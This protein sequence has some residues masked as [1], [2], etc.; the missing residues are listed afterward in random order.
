M[1]GDLE[2]VVVHQMEAFK[3]G[4]TGQDEKSIEESEY[5]FECI[6]LTGTEVVVCL[7]YICWLF[8][9]FAYCAVRPSITLC[10]SSVRMD[11]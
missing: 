9:C 11:D 6:Y 8:A 5:L 4:N 3:K 7:Q 10:S 2:S 1:E